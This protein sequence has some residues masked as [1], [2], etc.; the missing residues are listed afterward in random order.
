VNASKCILIGAL[1]ACIPV[2]STPIARAAGAAQTDGFDWIQGDWCGGVENERIEEHWL[3]SHGGLRLGLGRTL[4]GARTSSFEFLRIDVV[5]GVASYI[6]QPQGAPPTTFKRTAGG[7]DWVRFENP[8]HDFPKRVEYRR[9][10]NALYAEIAGPGEDGK[11][12]V[13]PSAYTACH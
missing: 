4:K 6:A 7:K 1:A 9:N 8:Q 5:D 10:G 3:S 2:L 11:E 12:L 13:I